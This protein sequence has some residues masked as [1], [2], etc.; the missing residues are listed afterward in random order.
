MRYDG[1]ICRHFTLKKSLSSSEKDFWLGC[2][3]D[4]TKMM[5]DFGLF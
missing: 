5:L 2:L 4:V 1:W 3:H